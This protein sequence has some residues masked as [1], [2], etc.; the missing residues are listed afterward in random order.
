MQP[1]FALAGEPGERRVYTGHDPSKLRGIESV[2]RRFPVRREKPTGQQMSSAERPGSKDT[3]VEQADQEYRQIDL[4]RT[5][6]GGEAGPVGIA[7]VDDRE[8]PGIGQPEDI[9]DSKV[10]VERHRWPVCFYAPKI[11]LYPGR[12][13]DVHAAV[14]GGQRTAGSLQQLGT[15]LPAG[16]QV[17]NILQLQP[18]ERDLPAL[19]VEGEDPGHGKQTRLPTHLSPGLCAEPLPPAFVGRLVL[20]HPFALDGDRPS[21]AGPGETHQF[22]I[23][24]ISSTSQRFSCGALATAE[25]APWS[26]LNLVGRP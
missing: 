2:G 11:T 18:L 15:M 7:P 24:N 10:A 4:R 25:A 1:A 22:W 5:Q 20:H 16:Q 8:A 3:P 12:L 23:P 19:I 26:S 13:R 14:D 6:I 9:P 21:R 17:T